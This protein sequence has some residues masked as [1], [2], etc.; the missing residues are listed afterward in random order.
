MAQKV[1]VGLIGCGGIAKRHIAWFGAHPDCAIHALCDTNA[2]A[3]T[4][5]RAAVEEQQ[6]RGPVSV[7]AS[8][9]ALLADPDLDAAAILL[10]HDL[11]YPV[12]MAALAAGKHVL[13]E[14]P[15][16]TQVAHAQELLAA[17]ERQGKQIAIGYQRSCIPEYAY[18]HRMIRGGEMGTV[19]FL[20]AHLEQS[21]YAM[22]TKGG[23]TWRQDPAQTGGGQLTDTGSHTLAALLWLCPEPPVEVFAQSE[24]CGL[25]VDVNT[26]MTLRF[27]NGI[28]AA[29]TIGGFGHSVTESIRVVGD[30]ASTRIFFRTVKEQALEVNGASVDAKAAVPASTPNANFVDAILGRDTVVADGTLGLRVAQVTEAAYRSARE[31]RPVALDGDPAA[32]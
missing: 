4:R 11:H 21:W 9:E 5:C 27:A 19:R 10:P 8:Y 29:V 3:A 23:G 32:R 22:A 30:K 6:G 12:A 24:S 26:V 31:H 16:V 28:L 25:D 7:T 14:K 2:D 17:A 18:V 1:R 20:T 15:M 13:I